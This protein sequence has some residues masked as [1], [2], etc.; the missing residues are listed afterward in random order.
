M[1]LLVQSESS[2]SF[3]LPFAVALGAG[4]EAGG[5]KSSS[6]PA[7]KLLDFWGWAF[8]YCFGTGA[9][10]GLVACDFV[11]TKGASSSSSLKR[12]LLGFFAGWGFDT[13]VVGKSAASSSSNRLFFLEGDDV[14]TTFFGFTISVSPSSSSNKPFF[15]GWTLCFGASTICTDWAFG[16]G[17]ETGSGF[18]TYFFITCY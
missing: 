3:F 17:C 10:A 9:G 12:L 13:F 8:G 7:N 16:G 6:S 15:L 4:F 14:G 2:N 5:M 18:L 11:V 1:E